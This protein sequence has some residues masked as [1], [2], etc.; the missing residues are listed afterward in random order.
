MTRFF[1]T[2]LL[3]AFCFFAMPASAKTLDVQVIKSPA[4]IE[5]WLVQDK[6]VPVISISFSFDGGLAYDPEDK[7]GVARMVSILLDEGAGDMDSQTFQ[8]KLENNAISLSFSPG[9][10]SFSGELKTLSANKDLAFSMLGLALSKPRFDRDAIQRM[11]N[12]NISEIK[13][14]MG[15]P[16]WLV[17]RTFNGMLFEG[18]FYSQ[19]GSGDLDSM[20]R[21]TRTDLMNYVED[22]FARNVLKVSIAGDISKEE[23]EAALDTIFGALPEKAAAFSANPVELKYPGKTVLLPLNTPQTFVMAGAPG[24]SHSDKDWHAAMIM[25]YILGGGSFDSRLMNEIREKRGLTYGVYSSLNS[26]KYVDLIQA[27]MSTSNDKAEEAVSILKKEWARMAENGPT[28]DEIKD[29]KDYLTGSLLLG[30][31]STDDISGA[32]NGL[33]QDNFGPDYIN[34]RNDLIKAVSTAD[35]KRIAKKILNT[36][37]LTTILVGQPKN[38]SADVMLDQPPGMHEPKQEER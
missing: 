21:I 4:G 27:S 15:D 16:N 31:T 6:T 5:A 37:T 18:H 8:G 25:N 11:K 13:Q 26:M 9:R 34:Q 3:F 17:A 36:D 32:L 20:N 7:P 12:A 19:P 1:F 2:T 14:N 30:L 28:D 33:Q 22:Q 35:V 24:I 10:D 23:A 38:V 29:A